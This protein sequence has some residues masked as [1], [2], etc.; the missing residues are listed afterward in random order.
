MASAAL[1]VGGVTAV[2]ISAVS[3]VAASI[4]SADEDFVDENGIACV[5]GCFYQEDAARLAPS[6]GA[7][8]ILGLTEDSNHPTF[9]PITI[10][11]F[12]DDAHGQFFLGDGDPMACSFLLSAAP[13]S[14]TSPADFTRDDLTLD[15]GGYSGPGGD[16][17]QTVRVFWSDMYAD[18]FTASLASPIKQCAHVKYSNDDAQVEADVVPLTYEAPDGVSVAA[19][20]ETGAGFERT[21][22][23]LQYVNLAV[24]TVYVTVVGGTND[25][26]LTAFVSEIAK[27]L[28]ALKTDPIARSDA[29][30]DACD[31][32]C[33]T[34]E[35]TKVLAPTND[36]LALIGGL[37]QLTADSRTYPAGVMRDLAERAWRQGEWF[38]FDCAFLGA[39]GPVSMASPGTDERLRADP[40]L[41]LGAYGSYR[42][43][44][45]QLVRVFATEQDAAAYLTDLNMSVAGCPEY[46]SITQDELGSTTVA[47]LSL[48]LDLANAGW[49]ASGPDARVEVVDV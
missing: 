26:E 13:I 22:V 36:D 17:T 18:R 1:I 8:H 34:L 29:G 37:P 23:D 38:P 2:A 9:E 35:Q 10:G 25:A 7:L 32:T 30:G 31:G 6:S 4:K 47:P 3:G 12:A 48:S 40:E 42:E 5:D 14:P 21:V 43:S 19:W 24:R 11:T 15:L 28:A 46:R 44:V 41:A 39:I 27:S 45:T 16:L 20:R 33:L 49:S